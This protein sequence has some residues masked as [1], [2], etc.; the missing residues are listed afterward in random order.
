MYTNITF[1]LTML[2]DSEKFDELFNRPQNRL[3]HS[4]GNKFYD[5][6]MAD[7]GILV[8]YHNKQYKKKVQLTVNTNVMLSGD[9]PDECNAEKLVSKLEKHVNGYFNSIYS[10][11]DFDISK[12]HLSTD[13]D[14]QSR[15][16]VSDYIRILKHIGRVKGFSPSRN[17]EI[18]KY[19][20]FCLDGNSNGIN[21][22]IYNLER[23]LKERAKEET[24]EHKELNTLANKSVGLLRVE[25]KL[26]KLA[27]I[28]ACTDRLVTSDQIEQLCGKGQKMFLN[29]FRHIVPFGDFYKKENA[30]EIIRKEVTDVKMRRRMI[31]LVALLPEKK[32]LMLAQK[33]LCYR[34]IDDV[35]AE[36]AEIEVSP[37]TIS[38]RHD[39]KMLE[40]IYKFM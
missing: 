39:V 24:S 13:I 35:M 17:C 1:E 14:V 37:V 16:K 18:G 7:K 4:A 12:M 11:D 21:F 3:S 38:K 34:Q 20:G 30:V 15:A 26:V 6:T 29:V 32:S 25:V 27:A 36:F 28:R 22:R 8:T 31:R 40:N 23:H 2:L 10:L 9:E 5:E 33:E 19:I